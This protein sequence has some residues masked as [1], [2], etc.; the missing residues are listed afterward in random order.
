M[1]ASAAKQNYSFSKQKRQEVL[2]ENIMSQDASQVMAQGG[3][4]EQISQEHFMVRA[5]NVK[6]ASNFPHQR[7]VGGN[8]MS[9]NKGNP[10]Q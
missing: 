6:G 9:T 1:A 10:S 7:L 4:I 5:G 3:G 8:T 2:F